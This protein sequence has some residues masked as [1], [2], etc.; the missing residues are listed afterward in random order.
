MKTD[1]NLN[2]LFKDAEKKK[3]KYKLT[4]AEMDI[5]IENEVLEK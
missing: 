3:P 4:A 1:E 2:Q 5:L